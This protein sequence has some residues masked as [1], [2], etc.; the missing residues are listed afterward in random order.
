VRGDSWISVPGTRVKRRGSEPQHAM[1]DGDGMRR[2]LDCRDFTLT[3]VSESL[4]SV[5]P[6]SQS[7]G[8]SASTGMLNSLLRVVVASDPRKSSEANIIANDNAIALAA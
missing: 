4:N 3:G 2:T 6:H 5:A 8:R 1:P 7:R